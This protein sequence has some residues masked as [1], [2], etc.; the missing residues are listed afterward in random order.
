MP[1]ETVLNGLGDR[2]DVSVNRGLLTT[3]ENSGIQKE[4]KK[5]AHETE[6]STKYGT[7]VDSNAER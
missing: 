6:T 2:E 4:K 3:L 7:A 5:A 1:V